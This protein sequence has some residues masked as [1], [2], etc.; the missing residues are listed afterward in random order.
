MVKKPEDILKKWMLAVNKGDVERLFSLYDK[1]AVLIPTFSNKLLNKPEKIREYFKNLIKREEL[2]VEL[3]KKTLIV[4]PIKN[5]MY[6][7]SGIY[8]WHFV[9]D[10][11]S[12]GFEAR[13]SYIIDLALSSP[14]IHHHS[15][16]I[17]RML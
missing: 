8:C 14:I 2:S 17:P 1:K 11:E 4:Q 15:S 16:Q 5:E 6:A 10:G 7:L 9:L 3:H 13:F 12:L